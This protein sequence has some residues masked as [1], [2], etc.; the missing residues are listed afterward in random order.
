MK[1]DNFIINIVIDG[2]RLPLNIARKDEELYR[3]AEK[4]IKDLLLKNQQKYSKNSAKE[5][6][7][8]TAYQLAV[9][10]SKTNFAQD[11]KP[12]VEK[13]EQWNKKMED[14]FSEN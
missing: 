3:D 14:F 7:S 12:V 4:K 13:V 1:D 11:T 8:I 9:A 10:L 6:L 5:V 2:F